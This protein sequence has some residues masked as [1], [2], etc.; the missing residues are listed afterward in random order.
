MASG[1]FLPPGLRQPADEALDAVVD[2]GGSGAFETIQAADDALDGGAYSLWVKQGTYAAG[3]T[4]STDNAYIFVEPGTVIEA[5]ITL[6][7]DNVTL[8][9]GAGCDIQG[10]ITLSGVNCSCIC[11]NGCDIDALIM[12]GNL[13][14]FDGGGW[15]TIVDGGAS[16][17]ATISG[18]DCIVKNATIDTNAGGS[19]DTIV[20]SGTRI[21]LITLQVPDSGNTAIHLAAGSDL[22]QVVG[23]TVLGA[24]AIG[25]L[26]RA[27]QLRIIGNY[28]IAAGTDC[29]RSDSTGDNSVIVGNICRN[30]GS[31]PIELI[32]GG[33]DVLVVGNRCDGAITDGS[34]GSTVDANEVT[35]F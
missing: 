27:P 10:T 17:A 15:D 21:S 34:T 19:A 24:D 23:C 32:S 33:D 14:L 7:G 2:V 8:V 28:I 1:T 35:A 30:P 26:M 6:S 25:I 3:F 11:Q 16:Q 13:G 22:S 29:I 18:D 12:S 5:G 4:V 31:D 9:L 20:T